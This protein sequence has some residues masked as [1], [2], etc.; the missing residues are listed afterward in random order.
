VAGWLVTWSCAGDRAASS[1]S[2]ANGKGDGQKVTVE[3]RW[4]NSTRAPALR[5]TGRRP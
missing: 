4:R 5:R 1:A 3:R 2:A